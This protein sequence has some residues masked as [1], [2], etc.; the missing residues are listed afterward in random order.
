MSLEGRIAALE[1]Q[2]QELKAELATQR[3]EST[4]EAATPRADV[5]DLRDRA[6][7]RDAIARH[8]RDERGA[9]RR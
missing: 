4:V 9:H 5:I 1:A 3:D 8:V 7:A 6:D 2:L